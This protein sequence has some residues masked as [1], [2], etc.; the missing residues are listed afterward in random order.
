[1]QGLI[2]DGRQVEAFAQ[3]DRAVAGK[4][5]EVA[6]EGGHARHHLFQRRQGLIGIVDTT[7]VEQQAQRMHS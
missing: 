1:M 4:R 2:D 3:T 6:G 7:V 5:L